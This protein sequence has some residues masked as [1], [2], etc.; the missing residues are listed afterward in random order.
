MTAAAGHFTTVCNSISTTGMAVPTVGNRGRTTRLSH[1]QREISHLPLF[2][3][4]PLDPIALSY[5]RWPLLN[6]VP[7]EQCTN[8]H[9][10]GSGWG[11]IKVQGS[12]TKISFTLYSRPSCDGTVLM[13]SCFSD[14][15]VVY[16][17]ISFEAQFQSWQWW[18]CESLCP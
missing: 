18:I 5:I 15:C 17:G 9:S 14:D 1:R 8:M 2:A 6:R 4:A 3:L 10:M 13:G 12:P 7:V 11:S 16:H